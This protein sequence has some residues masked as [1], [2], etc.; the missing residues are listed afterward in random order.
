MTASFLPDECPTQSESR[1]TPKSVSPRSWET[2]APVDALNAFRVPQKSPRNGETQ[3]LPPTSVQAPR[4]HLHPRSHLNLQIPQPPRR[5]TTRSR[6][7]AP[8]RLLPLQLRLKL[9]K[10]Y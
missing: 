2:S 4:P 10:R 1:I 6:Q 3:P 5:E 9:R 7:C 8:S